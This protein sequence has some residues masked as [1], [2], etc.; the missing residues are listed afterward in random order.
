M[1]LLDTGPQCDRVQSRRVG[2]TT[3]T[4]D[5]AVLFIG[6][7]PTSDGLEPTS[8]ISNAVSDFAPACVSHRQ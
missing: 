2:N 8:A 6:G 4:K 3:E 5:V 7:E 1:D